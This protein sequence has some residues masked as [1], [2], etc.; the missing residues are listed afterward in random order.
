MEDGPYFNLAMEQAAADE[1]APGPTY[2]DWV[3]VQGMRRK[4]AGG[5]LW[6]K[7]KWDDLDGGGESWVREDR[8]GSMARVWDWLAKNVLYTPGDVHPRWKQW[9]RAIE[10]GWMATR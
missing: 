10:R 4:K 6:F 1:A 8:M 5:K 9:R 3:A 7:V 2:W